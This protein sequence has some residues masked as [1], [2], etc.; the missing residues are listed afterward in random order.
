MIIKLERETSSERMQDNGDVLIE[1]K[2]RMSDYD[3]A[4]KAV[5]SEHYELLGIDYTLASIVDGV[6]TFVYADRPDADNIV[7]E[8]RD[9]EAW[10][11]FDDVI[12]FDYAMPF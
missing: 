11:I 10:M 12:R 6:Y 7:L 2:Q 8:F 9:G 1:T 3:F 5:V 4:S